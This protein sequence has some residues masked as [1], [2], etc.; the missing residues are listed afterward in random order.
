MLTHFFVDFIDAVAKTLGL[1][2][3][4]GSTKKDD[5][6]SK[7]LSSDDPAK[8]NQYDY[9]PKINSICDRLHTGC[10]LSSNITS[11]HL[12]ILEHVCRA[13]I[14]K[15]II[16]QESIYDTHMIYIKNALIPLMCADISIFK[17]QA[18]EESIY[19]HLDRILRME[20]VVTQDGELGAFR[21][22]TAHKYMLDY[23]GNC[24]APDMDASRNA[25][26]KIADNYIHELLVFLD[27]LPRIKKG[28]Q[29]C[30]KLNEIIND[31]T[32]RLPPNNFEKY[33]SIINSI[34][35]AYTA[36]I[37]L[38]DID[39][40][41]GM[42]DHF[43]N[44][45]VQLVHGSNH[46]LN[47]LKNALK[48]T[49][50]Y[51][52]NS[53]DEEDEIL[54]EILECPPILLVKEMRV[55]RIDNIINCITP[56]FGEPLICT[57]KEEISLIRLREELSILS[58]MVYPPPSSYFYRLKIDNDGDIYYGNNLNAD[59]Y[60]TNSILFDINKFTAITELA[61][62]KTNRYRN[63]FSQYVPLLKLLDS[64][65]KELP[66][67]ALNV[68]NQLSEVSL[69][70]FGFNKYALAVLTIGLMYNQRNEVIKNISLLPQV[71]HT[72][73][74]Q[75]NVLIP[76]YQSCHF[77]SPWLTDDV[78]IK[79]S[80]IFGINIYSQYN[81]FLARALYCYNFTIARH[82][83]HHAQLT[84]ELN[85]DF[86]SV[87]LKDLN[88]SSRLICHDILD[89]FNKVCGKILT[90]LDKVSTNVDRPVQFVNQLVSKK[91]IT[92]SELN[93]NLIHCVTGSY[94]ATCLLDY[95]SI[96]MLFAVPG[97]DVKNIIMLGEKTNIV[98]LLF[99]AYISSLPSGSQNKKRK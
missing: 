74:H 48:Y 39:N 52:Y 26:L 69:S 57:C 22:R 98:E 12:D 86:L 70:L 20:N 81:A 40:K 16:L 65:Q 44:T 55:E 51:D 5:E 29:T 38:Q 2:S 84:G 15:E 82:T 83:T 8:L 49:L 47:H 96:V 50:N 97:D 13:L 28:N 33:T 42:F 24:F 36:V 62:D 19:F 30:K 73:N 87:D 93:K 79:H 68:I 4:T 66:D 7:D 45:Y 21:K 89:E 60:S 37:I 11:N 1:S 64:I 63:Y 25:C 53:Y 14:R 80:I 95:L 71:T 76:A 56:L 18:T 6:A 92:R 3:P 54:S 23:I 46:L 32:E 85:N 41:T 61:N 91:I 58:Q 67:E 94:L 72:I 59:S 99:K 78:Y 90:G 9:L 77:G 75:G 35:T 43:Y 31:C 10:N 27:G 34:S 88:Y 17:D